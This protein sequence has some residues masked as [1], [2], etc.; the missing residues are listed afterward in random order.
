MG[1]ALG[2]KGLRHRLQAGANGGVKQGEREDV[3]LRMRR[4]RARFRERLEL[5]AKR[6]PPKIEVNLDVMADMLSAVIDGGITLSKSLAQPK[7]L[8]EQVMIHRSFVR[9]VFLGS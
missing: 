4:W 2:R 8:P 1:E 3:A 7:H 5:I 6:Y 9:L